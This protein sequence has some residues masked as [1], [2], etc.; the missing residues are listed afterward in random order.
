MVMIPVKS[1]MAMSQEALKSWVVMLALTIKIPEPI[2]DPT[3]NSVLS[4][5][6]N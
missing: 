4:H 5:N 6:P 2:I 3:P 1:H